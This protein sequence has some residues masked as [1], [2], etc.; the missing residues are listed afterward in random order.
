[1]SPFVVPK[2]EP[3]FPCISVPQIGGN[4]SVYSDVI[5]L[6]E[7][8]CPFKIR[9]MKPVKCTMCIIIKENDWGQIGGSW[10]TYDAETCS[11][12]NDCSLK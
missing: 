8:K 7:K 3:K 5:G 12:S 1:M 9:K 4:F 2:I 6:S 10:E 11:F